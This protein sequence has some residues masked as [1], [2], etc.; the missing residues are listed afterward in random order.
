VA[1]RPDARRRAATERRIS[2][3]V[4]GVRSQA[5]VV[6]GLGTPQNVSLSDEAVAE[7]DWVTFESRLPKRPYRPSRRGRPRR[8]AALTGLAA[9][10]L[11][12]RGGDPV[13]T[14]VGLRRRR[15]ALA[16]GTFATVNGAEL[17]FTLV[18]GSLVVNRGAAAV[19]CADILASNATVLLGGPDRHGWS[20]RTPDSATTA[21]YCAVA[22]RRVGVAMAD[23]V[24]A[25][26]VQ[27]CGA[28]LQ[29]VR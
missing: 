21:L 18:D 25:S 15:A 27:S 6:L 11:R 13:P 24:D 16:G 26:V 3:A 1:V 5:S 14:A 28:G 29:V 7:V 20:P 22:T 19:V 8:H 23:P 4:V 17:G 12:G 9:A 2:Y 10:Q